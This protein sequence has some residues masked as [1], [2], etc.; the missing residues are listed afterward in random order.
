MRVIHNQPQQDRP[1]RAGERLVG[2]EC[3]TYPLVADE[4]Q[5]RP[6]VAGGRITPRHMALFYPVTRAGYARQQRQPIFNS[7]TR[8]GGL[9]HPSARSGGVCSHVSRRS[10]LPVKFQLSEAR[11]A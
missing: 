9:L 8:A 2:I 11:V 3:P 10:A 7:R 1:S 5:G 6:H 4:A